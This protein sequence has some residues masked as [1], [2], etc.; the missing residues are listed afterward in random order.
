MHPFKWVRSKVRLSG[1]ARIASVHGP[2]YL[3]QRLVWPITVYCS[4]ESPSF[5]RMRIKPISL[6]L[7]SSILAMHRFP[8]CVF[9][10]LWLTNCPQPVLHLCV[11]IWVIQHKKTTKWSFEQTKYSLYMMRNKDCLTESTPYFYL[12]VEVNWWFRFV[13]YSYTCNS[14]ACSR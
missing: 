14:S 13:K 2:P 1:N 3:L 7:C 4:N 5:I 11:V 9:R 12:Y 6:K 10:L 8:K